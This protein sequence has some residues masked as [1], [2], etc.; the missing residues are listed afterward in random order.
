MPP[1]KRG[2]LLLV[3]PGR[4]SLCILIS[5][6]MHPSPVKHPQPAYLK[7]LKRVPGTRCGDW[8]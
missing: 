7:A 5:L 6:K 8:S 4:T 1:F 2:A 3:Y